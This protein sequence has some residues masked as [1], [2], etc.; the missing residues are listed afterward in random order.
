M[1]RS[2]RVKAAQ[3]A[4]GPQEPSLWQEPPAFFVTVLERLLAMPD[5][6]KHVRPGPVRSPRAVQQLRLRGARRRRAGALLCPPRRCPAC[7]RAQH[8]IVRLQQPP[9]SCLPSPCCRCGWR[10]MCAT[11]GAW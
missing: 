1:R 3:A 8:A 9:Q 7:R 10:A 11:T 6:T 4:P 5:G 2:K